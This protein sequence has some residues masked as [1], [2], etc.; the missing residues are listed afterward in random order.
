M[1]K[2][3]LTFRQQIINNMPY[4]LLH[5][6]ISNNALDKYVYNVI[7]DNRFS[8]KQSKSYFITNILPKEWAVSLAFHWNNTREG[9]SFWSDIYDKYN[10]ML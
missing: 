7:Y 8:T 6:L 5:C 4:L 2:K 10:E 1:K 9:Y 3:Q